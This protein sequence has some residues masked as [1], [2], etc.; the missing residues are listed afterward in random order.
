[1]WMRIGF[2][3]LTR[4]ATSFSTIKCSSSQQPRAHP[5]SSKVPAKCNG[6]KTEFLG[7]WV[8]KRVLKQIG[9]CA[10]VDFVSQNMPTVDIQKKKEQFLGYLNKTPQ[11]GLVPQ[12]VALHKN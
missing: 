11:R 10:F 3:V 5:L 2:F 7:L 9:G 6:R 4:D 12:S 1:M 8:M